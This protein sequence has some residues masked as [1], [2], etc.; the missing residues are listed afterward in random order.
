[1]RTG[2]SF[3]ARAA[4]G[5][6]L[7]AAAA[8]AQAQ[9][10]L[11]WEAKTGGA[12]DIGVGADGSVWI[13]GSDAVG[14]GNY[15]IYR[16]K[17]F[18]WIKMPGAAKRIDV[19]PRGNAWVVN[20]AHQIFRWNGSSWETINGSAN[21]IGIGA[22]GSVWI[23]ANDGSIWEWHPTA[24][25]QKRPG[26]PV[27]AIDVD[28]NGVPWVVNTGHQIFRWN[29]SGWTNIPGGAND[30]GIGAEGSV[31]IVG[32]DGTPFWFDGSKWVQ[33]PG[34]SLAAISVGPNGFPWGATTSRKVVQASS[35]NA[36]QVL[37]TT[38]KCGVG[39]AVWSSTRPD[40]KGP[41]HDCTLLRQANLKQICASRNASFAAAQARAQGE[42][43]V[44]KGQRI[45]IKVRT[46][47]Y[48]QPAIPNGAPFNYRD[49]ETCSAALPT[50]CKNDLP[51]FMMRFTAPGTVMP[52]TCTTAPRSAECVEMLRMNR[53][54][55]ATPEYSRADFNVD[56]HVE[57]FSDQLLRQE[58]VV[59]ATKGA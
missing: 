40:D 7:I 56:V 26:G 55:G 41:A 9:G 44:G 58:C 18:E 36:G 47:K 29:G 11:T 10:N 5:L 13:I 45:C 38:P 16:W 2:Y 54:C 22:N 53:L 48:T 51:E 35:P 21:D 23:V 12:T 49:V 3:A 19:D 52:K 37:C 1:M 4:A 20:A 28:P 31:W 42:C 27:I 17:E 6:W 15:G 8:L 59:R 39:A 32:T 24:G 14:G 57:M 34:S 50:S 30:I 46:D 33:R 43:P 25:W